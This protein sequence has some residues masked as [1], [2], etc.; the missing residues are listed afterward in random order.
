ML[1][2]LVSWRAVF[3]LLSFG[4]VMAGIALFV[5]AAITE[6]AVLMAV[7]GVGS[8]LTLMTLALVSS[9]LSGIYAAALYRYAAEGD[10]GSFFSPD[11]VKGAFQRK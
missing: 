9:A 11:M 4:T 6:S 8:V 3:G 1:L 5:A 10:A 7:V 2:E